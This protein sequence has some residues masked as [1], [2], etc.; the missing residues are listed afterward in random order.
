MILDE[1]RFDNEIFDISELKTIQLS[2]NTHFDILSN[3]FKLFFQKLVKNN[4]NFDLFQSLIQVQKNINEINLMMNK[5]LMIQSEDKATKPHKLV[6][7][8]EN[9]LML[10]NLSLFKKL[11]KMN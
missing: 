6:Q 1:I 3:K 7:L 8:K 4:I 10:K 11:F 9:N 2:I 5:N